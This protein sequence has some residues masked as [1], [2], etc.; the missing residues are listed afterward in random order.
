[1]SVTEHCV[2]HQDAVLGDG[3]Q[4]G[5]FSV[6]HAGVQLGADTVVGSHCVI[7]HPGPDGA[8]RELVIGAGSV[9]RSHTVVYGGSTFAGRLE[10][11]HGV[12]LREGIEAGANLRVGTLCDLQGDTSIG[13]YVRLHSGVF[14]G[15]HAALGDFVWIFPHAVLTNDPHPPSEAQEG[16]VV[17]DYAVIAARVVLL[18]GVRVGHGAVVGAGSVV[19]RDVAADDLVLG[20]PAKPHSRAADIRLHDAPDTAAYPWRRHFHR[21]YPEDVI[22]TW[23]AETRLVGAH[24]G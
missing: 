14:V 1:V 22:A 20:A 18:P 21:G 6:V 7:G 24:H 16:V 9:I 13:D 4:I 3:V 17:E 2:I 5:P 12:I 19:T 8:A 15:K 11:G 23:Q 10:T